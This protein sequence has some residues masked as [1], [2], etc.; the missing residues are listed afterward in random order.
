MALYSLDARFFVFFFNVPAP[1]EIYPLPLHDALPIYPERLARLQQAFQAAGAPAWPTDGAAK[2]RLSEWVRQATSRKPEAHWWGILE[3]VALDALSNNPGAD[4]GL[5]SQVEDLAALDVVSCGAAKNLYE[6]PQ[7]RSA[8]QSILDGDNLAMYQRRNEGT[9]RGT[10][11]IADVMV[12]GKT[13]IGQF[14][15]ALRRILYSA[16][17]LTPSVVQ[18]AQCLTERITQ[19]ALSV[20]A[21]RPVVSHTDFEREL[22]RLLRGETW[23]VSDDSELGAILAPFKH[24]WEELRSLMPREQAAWLRWL[25]AP[26]ELTELLPAEGKQI[27]RLAIND[28]RILGWF[29]PETEEPAALARAT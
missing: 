21:G 28:L 22:R 27:L 5:Y 19:K 25:R 8:V 7:D 3:Q 18:A 11:P 24:I 29:E 1:T 10:D 12:A 2:K 17:S 14:G 16:S 23:Q 26:H 4:L 15:G 6:G 9:P 20:K 13:S